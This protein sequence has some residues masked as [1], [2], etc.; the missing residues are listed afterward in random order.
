M[1][2][3]STRPPV[4]T[5]SLSRAPARNARLTEISRSERESGDQ[6]NRFLLCTL[7]SASAKQ[8]K[9]SAQRAGES[10]P[11][12]SIV[13]AVLRSYRLA[14]KD[15]YGPF[16]QTEVDIDG[17]KGLNKRV[18]DDEIARQQVGRTKS[19]EARNVSGERSERGARIGT[20]KEGH[21]PTTSESR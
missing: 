17:L 9:A 21:D 5:L 20:G 1:A 16:G 8:I 15:K 7:V 11:M 18:L 14:A 10:I 12:T 2:T 3:N 6:V 4:E 19:P 13:R